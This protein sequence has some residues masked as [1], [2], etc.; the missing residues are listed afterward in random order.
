V[1]YFPKRGLLYEEKKTINREEEYTI[2]HTEDYKLPKTRTTHSRSR[3]RNHT[4]F[5]R[6]QGGSNCQFKRMLKNYDVIILDPLIAMF[7]ADEN[8]NAY[9]R[10]FINLFTRWVTKEKKTIIFI[11]HGTK[12]SSQSMGASAF[13]DAVRLVYRVEVIKNEKS[14]MQEDDMRWIIL[15]K[16]NNGAKKYL[17][18]PKVKRQ[19]FP[20]KRSVIEIEYE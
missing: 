1:R 9:A 18:S 14:E 17:G 2:T 16:D 15:D 6:E 13:V 20:K 7:G 8:N 19:V 10:K 11:H 3:L 4:L 5:R 12:N